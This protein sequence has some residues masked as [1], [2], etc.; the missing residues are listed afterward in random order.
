MDNIRL[1]VK[2]TV[3]DSAGSLSPISHKEAMDAVLIIRG[4]TKKDIK[5]IDLG[6]GAQQV[7]GGVLGGLAALGKNV[8]D[9]AEKFTS[10]EGGKDGK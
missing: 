10:K 2:E 4:K 5:V 9:L 6:P 8:L 1:M 7:A 3:G